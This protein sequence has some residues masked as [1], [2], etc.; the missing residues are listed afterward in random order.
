MAGSSRQGTRS[1]RPDSGLAIKARNEGDLGGAARGIVVVTVVT[2]PRLDHRAKRQASER[3]QPGV[4]DCGRRLVRSRE[5]PTMTMDNLFGK[6]CR[7]LEKR[8]T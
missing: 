2:A 3:S 5:E 8:G 6:C 7:L 4:G 1:D